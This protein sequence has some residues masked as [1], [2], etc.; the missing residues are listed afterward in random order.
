MAKSQK[1]N[2][3]QKKQWYYRLRDKYRLV[4]MKEDSY[5]EKISFRLSRLNVF[6][7]IT[8]TSIILIILTIFIIA[9]TPLREYIPGYMDPSIPVKLYNLQ[10]K[11]DSLEKNL[12]SKDLY[13]NNIRNIIEGREITETSSDNQYED[14]NYDT[15][16]IQ[17]SKEDSI[18]RAEYEKQSKF[19]L[20]I[21][22]FSNKD[23]IDENIQNELLLFPPVSGFITNHFNLAQGHY[24]IDIVAEKG[25][26]IKSILDGTVVFSEWTL[27]TGYTICVQHQNNILSVYKHNSSLL[28]KQ[29]SNV[30]AGEPIAIIGS[31]G[32][33]T[34]G[35]HLHFEIWYN[36]TPV[37]PEDYISY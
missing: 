16:K 28:K 26:A 6:V 37:N 23:Y 27:E 7:A 20:F 14:I 33:L 11:A 30:T 15:I 18:L 24:G 10:R 2:K 13:I 35:P 31:S 3:S 9:F 19:N 8:T 25:D 29:G 36:G 5:E 4:I 34:T 12:A 32:E 22:D 17:P 1:K 21:S